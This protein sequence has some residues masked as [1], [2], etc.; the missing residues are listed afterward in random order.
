MRSSRFFFSTIKEA[1]ADA[2]LVSHQLMIRAG[3]VRRL[4]AGIYTWMP[5]GLR[6]LHKVAAIVR[7]EMN[8]AGAVELAMPVVQ[9]GELWRESGRWS[10]YGPELLRLKDRHEREFVIQPTS[11]EVITD[12]ARSELK[13]YRQLPVHFYQIQVKFRDER[14]PRFG[15]LR[16]REFIMKDGYSFHADHAGLERE[17]RNMY[18]TYSRIFTRLGLGFRAVAADTG[19]I[20]GTGSHEFQVLADS[21]EDAIAWCPESDYA[22]NVE[23]AEALA[24]PAPRALPAEALTRVETP[25]RTR[26]EDV[27]ALLKLP[28]E[29]TV[30]AIAVMHD[31]EFVLLLLRGDH[32]L[33]EVKTSKMPGLAPFRFA[34]EAEIERALGCKPGYIGPLG[35]RARVIADRT[36][37]AMSDFVCGANAEGFHLTGANWGRDAPEPEVADLRNV[38]EG[39]P[40]PDGR[41]RL[42]I[43]RGIEVGHIFQLR[44]KYSQAMKAQF[45]D[46]QGAARP[47]E[48]GCYG[49]GVT[50]IVAAA[51]EQHHD[52][53]GILF[54][55]AMAPF[56]ACLVPIG[57]HKSAAVRE[58]TE[59]LYGELVAAGIEVLLDDR[60]ERPGVLFADMDLIGV[61]HRLVVSER[62]LAGGEAEYKGRR[63]AAPVAVPLNDCV[64]H[65]GE[66]LAGA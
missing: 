39:D 46:E 30:K 33:N 32:S 12:L 25:E 42:R 4:A 65:L 27:A 3:L 55:R 53:R 21:G 10:A 44:T 41:G 61:P 35:A 64:Q 15:I 7:E 43:Q 36:A 59:R 66:R 60:S 31:E 58:A 20:G 13:S 9:P 8:R 54:P 26:C 62:G 37:A 28:L 63:D 40:S 17:Y 5:L 52:A 57:Y 29:R 56:E 48:M 49:I 11:E 6:V 38:V 22:A 16:G 1:P 47:M 50:R 34:S 18:D 51:I 45:L 23:L 19:A 24:P 14:R 2:E